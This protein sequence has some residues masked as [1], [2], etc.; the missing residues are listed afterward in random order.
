MYLL[1]PD[2]LSHDQND[3]H[4][5]LLQ[6]KHPRFQELALIHLFVTTANPDAAHLVLGSLIG[7]STQE[8]SAEL[9][10]RRLLTVSHTATSMKEQEHEGL[11]N[12]KIGRDSE[13]ASIL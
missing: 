2:S 13:S 1:R 12:Y 10:S 3:Q 8:P 9:H 11:N 4:W 7:G 6:Q 5:W